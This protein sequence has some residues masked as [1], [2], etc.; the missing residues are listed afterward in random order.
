MDDKNPYIK[1]EDKMLGVLR[2]SN[3]RFKS[4]IKDKTQLKG[5]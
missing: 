3:A 1:Q 2:Q 4:S 5:Y